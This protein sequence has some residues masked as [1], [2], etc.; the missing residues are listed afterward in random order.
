MY[1]TTQQVNL[2]W[3]VVNG[4]IFDNYGEI[5]E[6]Y[7]V[8]IAVRWWGAGS[9]SAS[10]S[11]VYYEEYCW[12]NDDWPNFGWECYNV[13]V[14]N[15]YYSNPLWV[16]PISGGT[17]ASP[18]RACGSGSGTLSLLNG[19]G[20]VVR[21]ESSTN[22]N[23]WVPISN[24]STTLTYSGVTT[25]THYRA[26]TNPG[27]TAYSTVAS[28][29]IDPV[30]VGGTVSP[31]GTVCTTGNVV[32][33][34]L[35]GHSPSI[36][37]WEV[38][39]G[40][41]WAHVNTTANPL[42]YTLSAESTQIRAWVQSGSCPGVAS[43]AVTFN[44]APPMPT[45]TASTDP[46]PVTL[47]RGTPPANVVWY[48]QGSNPGGIST[49]NSALTYEV[50]ESDYYYL[51][52]RNSAGCWS[53]PYGQSVVVTAPPCQ[54]TGPRTGCATQ[55][56]HFSTDCNPTGSWSVNGGNVGSGPSLEYY[57][58]SPGTY[59][60]AYTYTETLEPEIPGY[61]EQVTLSTSISVVIGNS[62]T[63][64]ITSNRPGYCDSDPNTTV[65]LS[66]AN[67]VAGVTY[68]WTSTPAGYT[69]T[70]TSLTATNVVNPTTFNVTATN[71]SC[72]VTTSFLFDVA[73]T[74]SQ[75]SV[76]NT[77]PYHK[78]LLEYSG[79]NLGN[80]YWQ[81]TTSGQSTANPLGIPFYATANGTYSVRRYYPSANCWTNPLSVSVTLQNFTP[82]LP[83][84]RQILEPGYTEIYFFDDDR[85]HI[86]TFADY[87][88]VTGAS[89]TTIVQQYNEG[90]VTKGSRIQQSGTYYLRGR[91]KDTGTWGP[92]LTVTITVRPDNSINSI[93]TR[94]FD[95][96]AAEVTVAESK[97]YF[98]ERGRSLQ[99][100]TKNLAQNAV[101][102]AQ[103]FEDKQERSVGS[104]LA[105][106]IGTSDFR[107]APFFA[108]APDG[109]SYS[110]R[111][112]DEPSNRNNPT[113]LDETVPGTLG[114][115]YSSRNPDATVPKTQF[116][117]SRVDFYEDGTGEARKAA[118]PGNQFRM[119]QGKEKLS[120]SFP[121]HNELN[122]Y[123]SKRS[124]FIP[125]ITTSVSTLFRG[126]VQQVVRDENGRYAISISDKNGK[127][128]LTAR[129]GS[130]SNNVLAVTNTVTADAAAPLVYFY[131][132]H[133]QAITVSGGVSQ[134]ENLVT[135]TTFS[136]TG[137]T[138]PAGFYRLK[139]Q[140]GTTTLT[141]TNYYLDVAY[142]FYDDAG[143]L[144]CSLSPNGFEAM[145]KRGIS[146]ITQLD[147]TNYVYNHQGWL[148]SQTETDAGESKYMYRRDGKIRFSENALQRQRGRFSYTHYD[149]LGRPIQSGEYKASTEVFNS[150][151]LK[152]KLEFASQAIWADGDVTDWIKT[153]YDLPDNGTAG[154]PSL[155]LPNLFQENQPY[156]Q[157]FMRGAVSTT[158]NANI[159]T[160]YSYDELG[161]VK[162]MIQKPKA[163]SRVFILEY[164]YDFLGNVLKVAQRSVEGGAQRERF[165]HHYEYD[166]DKRL[167]KAYTSLDG[168]NR[169][170][171]ASYLFYVHGPL[172]RIEL[173]TNLQG[174]DFVYNIHGWLTQINHPN[175]SHVDNDPGKDSPVSNG[176][177]KDVFGMLLDYYERSLSPSG[178]TSMQTPEQYH[179]IP[180][181]DGVMNPNMEV[182]L[183]IDPISLYKSSMRQVM[184]SFQEFGAGNRETGR[185]D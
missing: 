108:L 97:A 65:Q 147:K 89:S 107:F 6:N 5:F 44:R 129:A 181:L 121:I 183:S 165:Y 91:D 24:T 13:P 62:I 136:Y 134:L 154:L 50:N 167:T 124:I 159:K 116:P 151:A 182:A 170:L 73:K 96:T 76:S 36:M 71:T 99:T 118:A 32:S 145:Q 75:P 25:T 27:C 67:P 7:G 161:R 115:Y 64:T 87:F 54:I 15:Y 4:E 122:H 21:W 180:S 40:G 52:A 49:A 43:T 172:K 113:P 78:R 11:S 94:Q 101:L 48:W 168:V 61:S 55:T 112:F 162:W 46:G 178:V 100:Q 123:L 105:A 158:E 128:L 141:Y 102:A 184:T 176:M 169:T 117:Y 173:A 140:S 42:S 174:I 29:I 120:N 41:G 39:T 139:R 137:S 58:G 164:E 160:W 156:E 20:P 149:A 45:Y 51:R 30:S 35:S 72:S 148:L 103:G 66:V 23:T 70:G 56:Y 132:L 18:P 177:R 138:L 135:N 79:Y 31:A 16:N 166:R 1:T 104:T 60:I 80:H 90:L 153:T 143:R 47:T 152:S 106:P 171:Q 81:S 142:Q 179:K 95:G 22:L 111:H 8:S 53:S 57:F 10:G 2:D 82:P 126:G 131:L 133:D 155:S 163:L 38:N 3:N 144:V 17:V 9:V 12:F 74:Q 68:Q 119:G 14:Y 83:T 146:D 150:A 185:M 127:T 63:P 109:S 175:D 69:G 19:P 114:Y 86:L 33:V 59:S 28:V 157:T 37:R 98:D 92:A 26:V 130:A 88:W 93:T 34:T 84:V 85:Q 125:G 110:A 77:Q